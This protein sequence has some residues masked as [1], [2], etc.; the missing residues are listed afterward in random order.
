MS[1]YLYNARRNRLARNPISVGD[2]YQMPLSAKAFLPSLLEPSSYAVG[3]ALVS[4]TPL[5]NT[6]SLSTMLAPSPTITN[7]M[8]LRLSPV[9]ISIGNPAV[10]TYTAHG[11]VNDQVVQFVSTGALP[12]GLS[13]SPV[14]YYVV[15][16]TND[17]FNVS[18]SIGGAGISTSGT[19]SGT[20]STL[21]K[22]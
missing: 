7:E 13:V 9:T 17:T 5:A 2:F 15:N 12:T 11:L 1:S 10:I 22:V 4:P 20:Q 8:F 19:Q 18:A 3:T 21:Y 6:P 16:K 14:R